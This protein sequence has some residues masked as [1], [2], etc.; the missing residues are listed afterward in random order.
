MLNFPEGSSVSIKT[1]RV[2]QGLLSSIPSFWTANDVNL[3]V[4]LYLLHD[5]ATEALVM[6]NLVKAVAKR[7]PSSV[8][9]PTLCNTWKR[10]QDSLSA[11][12]IGAFFFLLKKAIHAA[13]RGELLHQLRA[14][15]DVFLG[16]FT[17]QSNEEPSDE[18]VR[19]DSPAL[20]PQHSRLLSPQ[21]EHQ[22]ISAFLE[23]VVKLNETTFKPLFRKLYDWAFTQESGMEI[24]LIDNLSEAHG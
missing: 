19:T 16:G 24:L 11:T 5:V 17:V 22:T 3:V 8:L 9:I 4:D 23:L 18:E 6:E 15:F 13:P 2:L 12:S 14:L 10:L 20:A 1:L 21:V 7:V